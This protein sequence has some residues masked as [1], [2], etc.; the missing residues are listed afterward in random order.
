MAVPVALTMLASC[1]SWSHDGTDAPGDPP[2]P[3]STAAYLTTTFRATDWLEDGVP[4]E[5]T[6]G[7]AVTLT[8]ATN[9]R[10]SIQ[11]GCGWLA[12]DY[13]VTSGRLVLAN[14]VWGH[15][16]DD[17]A[18]CTAEGMRQDARIATFFQSAPSYAR[19]V[20]EVTIAGPTTTLKLSR[21]N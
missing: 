3:A 1:G 11:T 9:G 7:T 16:L 2:V 17:T 8:L 10:A 21:Q 15:G 14:P 18:F 13:D 19:E 4:V 20:D 6:A 12:G 5:F